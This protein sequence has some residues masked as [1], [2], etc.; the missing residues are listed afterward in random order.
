MI[1]NIFQSE[2]KTDV[3]VAFVI[4]IMLLPRTVSAS[5]SVLSGDDFS[6]G[7]SVGAFHIPFYGY[8]VESFRYSYKMYKHTSGAFFSMFLQALLSPIN[9]GG[10]TQ[11]RIVMFLNATLIFA[12]TIYFIIKYIKK[13]YDATTLQCLTVILLVMYALTSYR[14]YFE[15][16]FQY[17]CA[18][19]YTFPLSVLVMSFAMLIRYHDKHL[20]NYYYISFALGVL[21]MG[22]SL[23]V[24]GLG[25]YSLM[26][27][28]L[29]D[30][31]EHRKISKKNVIMF[32]VWVIIACI[33]AFSLGNMSRHDY[34][35]NTGIYPL[36]AIKT[37][38]IEF[39]DRFTFFFGKTNFIVILLLI[40]LCGFFFFGDKKYSKWHFIA[41]IAFLLSPVV[42][43]FPVSLGYSN[44]IYHSFPDRTVFLID[45][46]F[47][48]SFSNFALVMGNILAGVIEKEQ[49]RVFLVITIMLIM[50]SSLQDNY[51]ITNNQN[52][53]VA[54]H[55]IKRDY[56]TYH[57]ECKEF[58]LRLDN[59]S[60]DVVISS[61]E[62]PIPFDEIY[63][64]WLSDD[65]T[66]YINV[67]VSKYKGLDSI[68]VQQSQ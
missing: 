7:V 24:V 55:L 53:I 60:G 42:I 6:H 32:I 63:P 9:N 56:Q 52:I 22:G 40:M 50:V 8:I 61:D 64:F 16:F 66:N 4:I 13:T 31:I 44:F 33:N 34:I 49:N 54:G 30:Y 38:F 62:F 35:D 23:T 1:R 47:V 68:S 18:I 27:Y 51:S 29:L 58:I 2:R 37:S 5:Y 3:L 57:K 10:V 39:H 25:C 15:V 20:V 67:A 36:L 19:S 17:S 12:C 46:A 59:E 11:L 45:F 65:I 48:L 14:L 28:V 21:A 41:S 26:L 43:A